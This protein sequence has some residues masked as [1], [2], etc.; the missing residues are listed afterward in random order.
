MN[1]YITYEQFIAEPNWKNNIQYLGIMLQNG[2]IKL[3]TV[4]KILSHE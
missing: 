2:Q 1:N 4:L 3:S